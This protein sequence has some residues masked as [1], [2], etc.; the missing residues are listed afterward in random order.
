M[1]EKYMDEAEQALSKALFHYENNGVRY[2]PADREAL[3]NLL[4]QVELLRKRL[5]LFMAALP[6]LDSHPIGEPVPESAPHSVAQLFDEVDKGRFI[7][8]DGPLVKHQAYQQLKELFQ[9]TQ[10]SIVEAFHLLH[11]VKLN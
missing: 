10:L 9:N 7:S 4:L 11:R 5:A 1:V 6:Y 2:E 8:P 3:I